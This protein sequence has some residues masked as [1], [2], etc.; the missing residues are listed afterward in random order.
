MFGETETT[1]EKLRKKLEKD[2]AK[3]GSALS[4]DELLGRLKEMYPAL[5]DIA[6]LEQSDIDTMIRERWASF[7][8]ARK[9]KEILSALDE[10]QAFQDELDAKDD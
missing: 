6:R 3:E 9:E 8:D 4:A 7:S 2:I 5:R 10:T 1:P